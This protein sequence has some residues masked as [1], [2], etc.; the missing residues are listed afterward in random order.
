MSGDTTVAYVVDLPAEEEHWL[1]PRFEGGNKDLMLAPRG[2]L[3]RGMNLQGCLR[4]HVRVPP[5]LIASVPTRIIV[6]PNRGGYLPDFGVVPWGGWKL[7]SQTFVDIVE[8]PESGA[9]E[10]LPIAETDDGKGRAVEK[11]FF[12]MNILQQFDA[13]DVE[14]STVEFKEDHYFHLVNGK[15]RKFT[16]RIMRLVEPRILTLKRPL[17]A[18]HHLWH[19]TLDDMYRV[20]FSQELYEAVHEARLSPL[21][22]FSAREI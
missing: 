18:G 16:T 15:K 1:D 4:Y 13:V 14:R 5:E 2:H 21:K 9:H 19:G 12:L 6:Q 17:V 20:F 10:F 7:V 22:Y 8:R 11:R 3:V